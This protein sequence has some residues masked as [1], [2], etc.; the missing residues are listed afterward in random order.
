MTAEPHVESDRPL[1]AGDWSDG[2]PVLNRFA[3]VADASHYMPLPD[4]WEIG[5][6]DVVN[7]TGAIADGRY[8]AVNLAGAG[9]ISAVSNALGGV[10]P[11]FVF[12]G[13]GAHF[14]VPPAK[15]AAAR[16]ALSRAAGW[17]QRDLGLELRAGMTTVAEVRA[18]GHDVRAAYW[19]ASPNIR[20]AM[21][22][23]GGIE[24]AEAR[25]RAGENVIAA[26]SADRDPDLTGLSC[27][28]GAILPRRG[29]ILSLI[30]KKLPGAD[31]ARFA[32]VA[33]A[34]VTILEE[35]GSVSPVPPGGPPVRW[36]L[37]ANGFQA[38][39]ARSGWPLWWRQIYV[40]FA[41][42]PIW[43][44]LK[45]GMRLGS[46]DAMRYRREVAANTDFRKFDDGLMMTVDCPAE[47]V[48]RL[49][50]LL[51]EAAGEGLVRYG[52]HTQD[53]A[54]MTCIV[55]SALAPD[56]MH[57]VDGAGGGYASAAGMLKAGMRNG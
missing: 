53:E 26:A 54:L 38:R 49:R 12:E 29:T 55:P 45:F 1:G 23:G 7:S 41:T 11:L 56:H 14:V 46:F 33:S 5:L 32:E 19:Q 2:V 57:F 37:L 48:E 30:V 40:F 22:A 35:T 13:D 42:V 34:A 31:D 8:K 25:M 15:A 43:M 44:I 10:L 4:D 36:P 27:Q 52:M 47:A 20:Y 6:S 39:I 51:D 21:F 28:W 3:D 9:T 24:W 17:A 18:A 16:D 50:T